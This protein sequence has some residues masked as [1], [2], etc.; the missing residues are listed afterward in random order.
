MNRNFR[1]NPDFD[2]TLPMQGNFRYTEHFSGRNVSSVA[3]LANF[4]LMQETGTSAGYPFSMS[5]CFVLSS[6]EPSL[7]L[8]QIISALGT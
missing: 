5:C 4:W 2:E 1:L 8:E 6:S 7:V 3:K